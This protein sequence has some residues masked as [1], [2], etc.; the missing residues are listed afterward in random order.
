MKKF[1]RL[2]L[3][4]LLIAYFVLACWT[5]GLFAR[6]VYL[7][8]LEKDHYRLQAKGQREGFVDVSRRRGDILDRHLEELAISVQM[9]SVFAH[10]SQLGDPLKAAQVLAPILRQHTEEVYKKLIAKRTFVYLA[11]KI[12]PRQAEKIRRLDLRGIHFQKEDKRV[13]PNRQLASHVLGFVGVDNDG[14]SGLE[15]HYNHLIRGEKTRVSVRMDALR[16]NYEGKT[17]AT[18]SEGNILVLNIDKSLQYIVEEIL[19][20]KVESS[21][22]ISGSAIVMDPN[23]GEILAMASYPCFDP[24]RPGDYPEEER[25][26]RSILEIYE[27]GSTFKIIPT[28]AVLNEGLAQASETLDCRVGTLRIAG[29]VYREATH[30]YGLLTFNQIMARSSN[31]GTIKLGLRLGEEKLYR[32]IKRFGF[33]EKTGIDLPGEQAGLL[34]PPS[35]WSKISIG[36]LSIGQEIGITPLQMIRAMAVVANGGYLVKPRLVRRILE[37]GGEVLHAPKPAKFRVLDTQTTVRVKEALRTAV[38]EGTGTSAGL[39][40]YSSAGKTGTAQKF[41]DGSYSDTQFIASYVGFAPLENPALAAMVVINEP[42][43]LYYGSQVAAPAFKQIMERSLIHLRIPQDQRV[44]REL[45]R[46]KDILLTE[47]ELPPQKLEQTVQVL[48]QQEPLAKESQHIVIL[49]AESFLLPDFSGRSFREVVRECAR[50]GLRLKVSGRGVAVGQRPRA[51]GPVFQGAVCEVFFS[52]GRDV[53]RSPRHAPTQIAL[54][55]ERSSKVP[56]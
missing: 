45:A 5:L 10:P 32:Y 28:A 33:G 14:L 30:S 4:R 31:V 49:E 35:Q 27:P 26:N 8:V 54:K 42:E 13:Y 24:N 18:Q 47:E 52:A 43:G 6:L 15:Y 38:E 16:Q 23:N 48:R 2:L 53:S 7:Q 55:N 41:I 21:Q 50:L 11:R 36:A 40:G 56:Q 37:P 12:S 1:K 9:G 29:K 46:A 3:R 39:S 17:T 25:R 20:K 34:R 19:Q 51:G 44:R 22:A